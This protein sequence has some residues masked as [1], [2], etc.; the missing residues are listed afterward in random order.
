MYDKSRPTKS[1]F[2]F[3]LLR[4]PLELAGAIVAT[5]VPQARKSA[6]DASGAIKGVEKSHGLSLDAMSRDTLSWFGETK[7]IGRVRPAN[8][9][10]D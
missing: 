1:K 3:T 7:D 9:V 4:K 5:L 10:L 2:Q 8:P 6:M